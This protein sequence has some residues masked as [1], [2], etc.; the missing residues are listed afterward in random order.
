MRTIYSYF[1]LNFQ[2]VF[3]HTNMPGEH[4]WPCLE[5]A[6]WDTLQ[7]QV[8]KSLKKDASLIEMGEE[9]AHPRGLDRTQQE[10][11]YVYG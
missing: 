3:T 9:R 5:K 8:C 7:S 2:P 1:L 10:G 6:F 11:K 4:R